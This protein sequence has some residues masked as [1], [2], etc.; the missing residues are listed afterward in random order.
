MVLLAA[1][2]REGQREIEALTAPKVQRAK[3]AV[4]EREDLQ[5]IKDPEE[6]MEARDPKVNRVKKVIK[7]V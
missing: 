2:V 3:K 7:E 4:K 1:K 6:I 5:E